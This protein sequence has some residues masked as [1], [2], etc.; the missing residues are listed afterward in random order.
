MQRFLSLRDLAKQ[1]RRSKSTA[2]RQVLRWATET[3]GHI[4]HGRH[5]GFPRML[6]AE[7]SAAHFVEW[8]HEP[9]LRR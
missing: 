1:I 9:K 7:S 2:H 4:L 5:G 3:G 8:F 6:L